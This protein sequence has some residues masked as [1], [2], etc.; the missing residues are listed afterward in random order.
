[1]QMHVAAVHWWCREQ[2][3]ARGILEDMK[4]YPGAHDEGLRIA[5]LHA[6]FGEKDS[7]FVWLG[8]QRWT[9][10][11]LS[12]LRASPWLDS[13]RSDPRFPELLER[14]GIRRRGANQN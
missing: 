4:M 8:R 1:M 7:A 12:Y 6:L 9:M 3:R 5:S 13:L 2:P 14:L 10:A 11:R